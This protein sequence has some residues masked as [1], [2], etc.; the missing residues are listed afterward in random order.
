M[1]PFGGFSE[2]TRVLFIPVIAIIS[3]GPNKLFQSE[4]E[5]DIEQQ[6]GFIFGPV[7]ISEGGKVSERRE[8]NIAS[9]TNIPVVIVEV[10]VFI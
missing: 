4:G 3:G 10:C 5:A 8:V 7:I 9:W 2:V 1:E 6:W